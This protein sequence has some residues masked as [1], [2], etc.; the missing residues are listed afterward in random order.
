MTKKITNSPK[1]T[2]TLPAVHFM[3]VTLFY[4]LKTTFREL[5]D[6]TVLSELISIRGT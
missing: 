2:I 6:I 1:V 4:F 5:T 3:T